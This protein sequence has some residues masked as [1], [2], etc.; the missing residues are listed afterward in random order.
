MYGDPE[1]YKVPQGWFSLTPA[2][3]QAVVKSYPI[4][5]IIWLGT[6]PLSAL[7]RNFPSSRMSKRLCMGIRGLER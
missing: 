4:V 2:F 5:N 6:S 7:S 3:W 1:S